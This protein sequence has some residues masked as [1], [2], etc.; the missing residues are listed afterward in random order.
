VEGGELTSFSVLDQPRTEECTGLGG[1]GSFGQNGC[2]GFDFIAWG[3]G[4][5]LGLAIGRMEELPRIYQCSGTLDTFYPSPSPSVEVVVRIIDLVYGACFHMGLLSGEDPS[6]WY[7][8]RVANWALR[9]PTL[10]HTPVRLRHKHIQVDRELSCFLQALFRRR[11]GLPLPK[12]IL[13]LGPHT[14][15]LHTPLLLLHVLADSA[16]ADGAPC[17]AIS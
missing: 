17:A 10:T 6:P 1:I 12:R 3:D 8:S 2:F 4:L 11:L 16:R 13:N 15:A 7:T 9:V 14:N 5:G